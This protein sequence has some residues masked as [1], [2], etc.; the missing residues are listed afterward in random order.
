MF[1]RTEIAALLFATAT[2]AAVTLTLLGTGKAHGQELTEVE[3]VRALE[4]CQEWGDLAHRI[5]L[6]RNRGG[7]LIEVEQ[8]LLSRMT[9]ADNV[10]RALF[11]ARAVY[12]Y[13]TFTAY[14]EGA[15]IYEACQ[16]SQWWRR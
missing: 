14:D 13:P 11:I 7:E 1:T 16:L 10:D 12:S 3:Q 15:I 8:A 9:A 5:A 2:G 4:V 6:V